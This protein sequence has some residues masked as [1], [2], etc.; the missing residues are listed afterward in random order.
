MV[1]PMA[2][3]DEHRMPSQIGEGSQQIEPSAMLGQTQEGVLSK[4]LQCDLDMVCQY[5]GLL[6]EANA[7]PAAISEAVAQA[8]K[9]HMILECHKCLDRVGFNGV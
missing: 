9:A 4:A 7:D 6:Y 2:S 3:E 5:L 1:L 8:R